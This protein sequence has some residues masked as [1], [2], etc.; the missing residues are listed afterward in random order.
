MSLMNRRR[1][2]PA[3]GS[4]ART[5][6][7]SIH[8]AVRIRVART[9]SL[10]TGAAVTHAPASFFTAGRVEIRGRA[11]SRE[12]HAGKPPL[13]MTPRKPADGGYNQRAGTAAA[14]EERA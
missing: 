4:K 13:P 7:A 6:Q 12:P 14:L 3:L 9:H 8:A 10:R 1:T 2:A 5:Q 11:E